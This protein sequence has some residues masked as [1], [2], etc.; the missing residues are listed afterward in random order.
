M[1]L[2]LNTTALIQPMD[3]GVLEAMKRRYRKAVL[4]TLL[5]EDQDGRSIVEFVKINIKDVIYTT[6]TAC[7][8]VPALTIAKSWHILLG[9]DGKDGARDT[10]MSQPMSTVESQDQQTCETLIRDL[11]KNLTDEDIRSWLD[12]DSNDP[13][14]Q[15]LSDDDIISNITSPTQDEDDSEEEGDT[16]TKG[17][18]TCGA[19]ADMLDK[20]YKQQKESSATSLLLSES[21]P[22]FLNSWLRPCWGTELQKHKSV[23]PGRL[24]V[25]KLSQHLKQSHPSL[26]DHQ[27]AEMVKAVQVVK[28]D[29]GR[30]KMFPRIKGQSQLS[31]YARSTTQPPKDPYTALAESQRGTRNFPMFPLNKGTCLND[32]VQWLTSIEGKSRTEGVAKDIAID[33]SKA[34]RQVM[35]P[36]TLITQCPQVCSNGPVV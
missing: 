9:S 19:V 27:R 3:Q 5:L 25:K 34:L 10:E 15:L 14:Y 36:G 30:R 24:H 1:Y 33:V 26:T 8:D 21:S 18:P 29:S 16:D 35:P 6:A 17:I 12:S 28:S 13:G 22:P 7:E 32:F 23:P 20:W 2:P 4:R 31:Q 11:D